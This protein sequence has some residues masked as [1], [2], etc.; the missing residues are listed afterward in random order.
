MPII[1]GIPRD[2]LPNVRMSPG[3]GEVIAKFGVI[4]ASSAVNVDGAKNAMATNRG[5]K[6]TKNVNTSF[7]R[8]IF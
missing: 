7:N 8:L 1:V 3:L 6:N 2:S 5:V 4:A